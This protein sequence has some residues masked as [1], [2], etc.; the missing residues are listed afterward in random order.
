M[1]RPHVFQA[2]DTGNTRDGRS[3]EVLAVL[4]KP[5][6]KGETLLVKLDDDIIREYW[7]TGAY[8]AGKVDEI[9]LMVPRGI[10][11]YANLYTRGIAFYHGCADRAQAA[12]LASQLPGVTHLATAVPFELALG[13]TLESI[14]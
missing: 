13:Q 5:T 10:T 1:I 9:D 2:G 14:Q 12:M 4:T 11:V 3:Y 8:M 6:N 7:A